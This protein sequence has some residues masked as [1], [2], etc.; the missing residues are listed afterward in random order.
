MQDLSEKIV[1]RIDGHVA[2]LTI[3]RAEKRNAM[4]LSMWRRFGEQIDALAMDDNVR[5][6]VV[7]G[8][9]DKCF[10]AGNDISEFDEL[11]RDA[12]GAAQYEN[13]TK[14]AYNALQGFPK[15]VIARVAGYCVGGGLEIAQMCDLQVASEDAVFGVTPARLGL[16]YKLSDVQLLTERIPAKFAREMLYTGD[17][18]AAETA[19]RWGL[20]N[21]VVPLDDLDTHVD[22]L[23]AHIAENAP[24]SVQAAKAIV[25]EAVKERADRDVKL[26]QE[27]V[28]RCH[29]S[30]D[31]KEGRR[32]FAEKRP[33]QFQGI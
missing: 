29:D 15:P 28:D 12:A 13:T 22:R 17:L 11:R 9:G 10:C 5:V 2:H 8:A 30:E 3:D 14:H 24:L 33:P 1:T 4:A 26:C 27:H 32:A 20:V 31:Y 16:G 19:L 23:A 6:L 7:K 25:G 21:R 18:Y